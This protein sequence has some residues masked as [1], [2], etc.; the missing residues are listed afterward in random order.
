MGP[1]GLR[2]HKDSQVELKVNESKP[3]AAGPAAGRL[4]VRSQAQVQRVLQG[5]GLHSSTSQLNLSRF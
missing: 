5:R 4:F 3:L 2:G 1:V